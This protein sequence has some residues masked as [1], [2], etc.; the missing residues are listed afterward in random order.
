MGSSSVIR[1]M[2][3]H[4]MT[5]AP[6]TWAYEINCYFNGQVIGSRRQIS[7]ARNIE[8]RHQFWGA[9]ALGSWQ[10]IQIVC[11]LQESVRKD[12]GRRVLHVVRIELTARSH[13]LVSWSVYA[14]YEY[15][16]FSPPMTGGNNMSP[17]VHQ[18][19][20]LVVARSPN[21]TH[22]TVGRPRY[23]QLQVRLAN[24]EFLLPKSMSEFS[25]IKTYSFGFNI[26]MSD[27]PKLLRTTQGPIW[28]I[29]WATQDFFVSCSTGACIMWCQRVTQICDCNSNVS[30]SWTWRL[31]R[32][33]WLQSCIIWPK[34]HWSNYR[35]NE[36]S[37]SNQITSV[38]IHIFAKS[39]EID[40]FAKAFPYKHKTQHYQQRQVWYRNASLS[41]HADR[42]AQAEFMEDN[43]VVTWHCFHGNALFGI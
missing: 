18:C 37:L 16:Y 3:F 7:L 21:A 23:S 29:H 14:N 26:F 28:G 6:L 39:F 13:I 43:K 31:L 5:H 27:S 42:C 25:V 17:G 9:R 35:D 11:R 10:L 1:W 34:C 30:V 8:K 41:R 36:F 33:A 22:K 4:M 2:V 12:T 40:Y 38:G 24:R 19:C 15:H 20:S 32:H